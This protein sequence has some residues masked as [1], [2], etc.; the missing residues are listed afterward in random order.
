MSAKGSVMLVNK[1]GVDVDVPASSELCVKSS[2]KQ[3]VK[4]DLHV[5]TTVSDGSDS[6]EQILTLA[7]GQGLT[8]LAFTDHDTLVG[9]DRALALQQY[10][11][12]KIIGGIE[13]SAWDKQLGTKVHVLGLGFSSSDAPAIRALCEPL[14]MR[15]LENTFWQLEQLIKNWVLFDLE[16]IESYAALS[17]CLYKQH[18]MAAITDAPFGS[19]LYDA[20]YNQLFK[21]GGIC[22]RDIAYVDAAEAVAA[23]KADGGLAV[24]AHAGQQKNYDVVPR[25]KSVGL[26]GIEKYHPDH[27][28]TEWQIIDQLASE[29]ALFQT[30]GSDYHGSFDLPPHPGSQT[31]NQLPEALTSELSP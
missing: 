14:L 7:T 24:L 4:A 11:A 29:Y 10:T 5:H 15:R 28:E 17:S 6:F 3:S 12:I 25:L 23:I 27:G 16:L 1:V 2:I 8:H 13:I 18:L 30:G 21:N 26:D 20:M 19:S 9:L 22:D 31:I